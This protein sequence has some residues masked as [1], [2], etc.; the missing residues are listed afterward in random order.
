MISSEYAAFLHQVQHV[1]EHSSIPVVIFANGDSVEPFVETIRSIDAVSLK[2]LTSVENG[3]ISKC[4]RS[5]DYAI[6]IRYIRGECN[7]FAAFYQFM[8]C[9][10][11]AICLECVLYSNSKVKSHRVVDGVINVR[12]VFSPPEDFVE[13]TRS[14]Q[15]IIIVPNS[16][17]DKLRH[18]I[19]TILQDTIVRLLGGFDKQVI[20][21]V[22]ARRL[23]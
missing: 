21:N 19:Q 12:L 20:D 6:P 23:M 16:D 5:L 4:A 8:P 2:E 17:G 7:D 10:K 22:I 9:L 14:E 15:S 1:L 18:Y 3:K 11:P 13:V